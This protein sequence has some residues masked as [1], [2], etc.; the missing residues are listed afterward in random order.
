MPSVVA[1]KSLAD[2]HAKL[3]EATTTPTTNVRKENATDC[4]GDQSQHW[5]VS[6]RFCNVTVARRSQPFLRDMRAIISL[7]CNA[8]SA[9]VFTQ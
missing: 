6:Q 3:A 4:A 7:T 1:T 5:T 2:L 9:A 8:R